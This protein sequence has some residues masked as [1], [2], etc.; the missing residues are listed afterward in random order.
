MTTLKSLIVIIGKSWGSI[1]AYTIANICA[2]ALN[3]FKSIMEYS[4]YKTFA[5][6]YSAEHVGKQE[7][8]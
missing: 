2:Y 6:K 3:N 1:I 8:S 7:I 5:G 4:M